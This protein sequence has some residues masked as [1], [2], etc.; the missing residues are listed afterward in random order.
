MHLDISGQENNPTY[1]ASNHDING[2][3]SLHIIDV[4]NLHIL[5]TAQ[6]NYKGHRIIA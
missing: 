1:A 6:I 4:D 5:A 2:L 3:R